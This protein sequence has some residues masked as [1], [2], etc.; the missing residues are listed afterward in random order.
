MTQ[1]SNLL[2]ID[3][4]VLV[5]AI[6]SASP[7][8]IAARTIVDRALKSDAGYCTAPQVL[9][10]FY[11]VVTDPRRVTSARK[12]A[13]AI[14][15]VERILEM[16]GLSLLPI[17][18]DFARIWLSLVRRYEITRQ[19]VFDA[20]IVALMMA[21]GVSRVSTFDEKDFERFVEVSIQRPEVA[22]LP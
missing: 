12:P 11:A 9:A 7:H 10:E 20:Q 17:P 14:D 2:F 8:H 18:T 21:N 1:L 19:D 15:D 22:G 5:Y 6:F 4:I 16:P 13:E 3:T